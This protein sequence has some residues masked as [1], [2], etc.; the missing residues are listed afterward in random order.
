MLEKK[1]DAF[2]RK[3]LGGVMKVDIWVVDDE[4]QLLFFYAKFCA[5]C[6]LP[7]S[8]S[9]PSLNFAPT[10]SSLLLPPPP[11]DP[12]THLSASSILAFKRA[13]PD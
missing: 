11:L 1:E 8:G 9:I 12:I 5:F 4:C 10:L 7:S 13:V 3:G 2:V 6:L